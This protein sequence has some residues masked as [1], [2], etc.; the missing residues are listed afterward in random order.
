MRSTFLHRLCV[1]PLRSQY[2][3][4]TRGWEPYQ[5]TLASATRGESLSLKFVIGYMGC[6]M[7]SAE[8]KEKLPER[9]E[10]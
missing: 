4:A 1:G 5:H 3:T 10:L 6:A 8:D 7:N 2:I 9:L